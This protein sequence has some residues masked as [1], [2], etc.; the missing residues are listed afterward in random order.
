M[1]IGLVTGEFPPMEGG[2]GAFTRE[3]ARSLAAQGHK[4]HV[5]TH[6]DARP[7]LPDGERYSLGQLREPVETEFGWLHPRAGRWRWGDVG[8]IAD[9]ALRYDLNILNIQYQAAAYNMRSPAI[10]VA[11]WRLRGLATTVVTYHDLRVPYLFPKAGRLRRFFVTMMARLAHGAIVTNAEDYASLHLAEVEAQRL[12][13]IPIGSN[14]AV[15]GV[16]ADVQHV[17]RRKL[18]VRPTDFLLGYFG[19]LNESK[20][21]DT[22][23]RAMARLDDGVH[24]VFI[25][26]KT[27]ASDTAN[28]AAFVQQL[29]TLVEELGLSDRVHWTGFVPDELVSAHMAAADLMV[30]PYRDGVSLRRG[31]LMAALA[32]GRPIISTEPE[33]PVH[34]LEH[35]R[36]IWL[37]PKAD[38]E[39]LAS[40]IT[41]LREA[42]DLRKKLGQAAAQSAQQFTWESIAAD[43]VA[44]FARL[45]HERS[46]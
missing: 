4:I 34:E 21:A 7:E 36:N 41:R 10:N 24:L 2:V 35:G 38:H 44:F 33:L 40:A 25:G 19:F 9:I 15:H 29:E 13:Q 1:R 17:V 32:H 45:H 6:R 16:D 43:T 31:T 30:L 11:P 28:N 8:R 37:A 42:P 3:L 20:G 12:C 46:E 23:L 26:G 22:L 39:A 14:I 5:I 27:G 18:S